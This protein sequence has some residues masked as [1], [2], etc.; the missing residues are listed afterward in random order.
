MRIQLSLLTKTKIGDKDQKYL[1]ILKAIDNVQ[2]LETCL[3]QCSLEEHSN[4]WAFRTT[5]NQCFCVRIE[6]FCLGK[7][8]LSDQESNLTLFH[9]QSEA[10][11]PDDCQQ[12][13]TV[14][15]VTVIY[16]ADPSSI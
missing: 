14:A 5:D 4:S 15:E 10:D 2:N 7:L 11:N 1:A 16:S 6:N 9:N 3:H 13:S 12:T 8:S